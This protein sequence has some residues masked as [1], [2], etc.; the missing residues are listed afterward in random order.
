MR[1]LLLPLSWLYGLGVWIRNTLYNIGLLPSIGFDVPVIVIG[2]LHAGGTGKS[3]LI[4]YTASLLSSSHK[5]VILSRGYGRRTRGFRPVTQSDKP[6]QCGDEPLM[7][8]N[9]LPHVPVFV[10]ES[11]VEGIRTIKAQFPYLS[12]FLLDDAFQHRRLKPGFSVVLCPFTT[13]WFTD[14]LLPAG[15]LREGVSGLNRAD[16]VVVTKCPADL[17]CADAD[18]FAAKLTGQKVLTVLFSTIRYTELL[19]GLFD[20]RITQD[21][22]NGKSVLVFSGIADPAPLHHHL[23][24]VSGR[25]QS[26]VFPDHHAYAV[27]DLLRIRRAFEQIQANQPAACIVTTRKDAVRLRGSEA[28]QHLGDLPVYIMDMETAFL[29]DGDKQYSTSLHDYL[30]R[31]DSRS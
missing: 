26:I 10:C 5:P 4:A 19:T 21:E 29:F 12:P 11:R 15:N 31:T 30:G 6:E 16:L 23:E 2:N 17:S 18:R 24:H 9:M 27:A 3:P 7:L 13:P 14:S 20:G 22:L 8:F 25:I 28:R 1:R